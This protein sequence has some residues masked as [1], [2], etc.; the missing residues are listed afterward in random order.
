[1]CN[2]WSNKRFIRIVS[3]E[4]TNYPP[5]ELYSWRVEFCVSRVTYGRLVDAWSVL[6]S[7]NNRDSCT[8]APWDTGRLSSQTSITI[9]MLRDVDFTEGKLSFTQITNASGITK[10]KSDDGGVWHDGG[11]G[12]WVFWEP[13]NGTTD[14]QRMIFSERGLREKAGEKCH[15]DSW[16]KFYG[17]T[18]T[19]S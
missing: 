9:G 14:D 19:T 16:R 1:M 11:V 13:R 7:S 18:H 15:N 4:L 6:P 5:F 3:K 17:V 2:V 8:G 12:T 10:A